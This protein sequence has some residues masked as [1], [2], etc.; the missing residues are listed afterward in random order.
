[1]D[2]ATVSAKFQLVIPRRVRERL[3]LK[4]GDRLAFVLQ[5]R[6]LHVVPVGGLNDLRGLAAGA[7]TDGVRERSA[8]AH[9]L[10]Q[11]ART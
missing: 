1:M 11:S 2:T 6:S 3:A 4:P 5:G 7:R 8:A 9:S 10:D